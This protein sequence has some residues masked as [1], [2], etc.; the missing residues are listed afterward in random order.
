MRVRDLDLQN[1]V[2]SYTR[3]PASSIIDSHGKLNV[4]IVIKANLTRLILF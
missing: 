2:S 3:C 4:S 1:K